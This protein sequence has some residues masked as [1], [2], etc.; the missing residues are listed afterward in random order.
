MKAVSR[1]ASAGMKENEN[2]FENF[3]SLDCLK[4]KSWVSMTFDKFATR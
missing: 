3:N 4:G 1:Q 2:T